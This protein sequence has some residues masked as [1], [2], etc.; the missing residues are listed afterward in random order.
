MLHAGGEAHVRLRGLVSSAFRRASVEAM[1]PR[2][3]EMAH[4]LLD[5][6]E[7]TN[8]DGPVDLRELFAWC[9]TRST[10]W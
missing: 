9:A 3:E 10:G 4:A 1:R 6:L 8:T 5:E 7:S 2:I